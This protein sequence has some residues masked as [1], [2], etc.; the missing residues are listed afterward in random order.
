MQVKSLGYQ[1]DLAFPGFTGEIIDRGEYLVI[2]TPNNPS[3]YWGNYIL[4][5]NP[6]GPDDFDRW[7]EIFHQ[8]IGHN[9][10]INH[11][12]FGWDDPS[13]ALGHI[14]PFQ[15]AGYNLNQYSIMTTTQVTR[16]TH[17]NPHVTVKPIETDSEW[18]LA[19]QCVAS[20]DKPTTQVNDRIQKMMTTWQA[21]AKNQK[22][23][24]FGAYLNGEFAGGLGIYKVENTGV[25]DEVVTHPN[26]R[27]QGV[28]RT[29]VYQAAQH[30][31]EH[32]NLQKLLLAADNNSDP[33]RMYEQ[34]GFKTVEHQVGLDTA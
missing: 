16:P 9:P 29:L 8:E 33:K 4:F 14:E 31:R 18:Q 32:L 2:R 28:G 13:G 27:R 1:I 5:S 26:F 30:A 22:A 17:F 19:A 6:P 11:E 25:V 10:A 20:H 24:W 23:L 7:R 15:N 3:Y 34:I 21:L 12:A